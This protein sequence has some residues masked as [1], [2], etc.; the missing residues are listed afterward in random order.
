MT[1]ST[2]APLKTVALGIGFAATNVN[3]AQPAIDMWIDDVIVHHAPVTCS[4][5]L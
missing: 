4:D 3:D 2:A 1:D 5:G